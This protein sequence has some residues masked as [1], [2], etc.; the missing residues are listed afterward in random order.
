MILSF[1][2]I[3]GCLRPYHTNTSLEPGKEEVVSVSGGE[4]YEGKASYYHDSLAGNHTANGEVYDPDKL[5]AASRTLPF[6]S[7]VKVVRIDTGKEVIVRINDRGPFAD[8]DRI[9][10]LS[11]AAAEALDM[12]VVGVIDVRLEVVEPPPGQRQ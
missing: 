6:G 4:T 9:I 2:A 1:V 8:P 7:E 11:R 12:M 10:D 5:T 3:G